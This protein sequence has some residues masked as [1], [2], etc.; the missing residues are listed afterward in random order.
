VQLHFPDSVRSGLRRGS[1]E[2]I[3]RPTLRGMQ[4]RGPPEIGSAFRPDFHVAQGIA[5]Y[6]PRWEC[7][8][9]SEIGDR[10]I[11]HAPLVYTASLEFVKQR[12]SSV[13]T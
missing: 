10:L 8:V 6:D 12:R 4:A 7:C 11:L 1:T 3:H 2:T 13:G 5:R 9:D